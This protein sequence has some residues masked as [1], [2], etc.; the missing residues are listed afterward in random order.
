[1]SH[2]G[3]SIDRAGDDFMVSGDAMR[4]QP[5]EV[6]HTYDIQK[7]RGR[8]GTP[9]AA[10]GTMRPRIHRTNF[11][12]NR[13]DIAMNRPAIAAVAI[14]LTASLTACGNSF[15]D[16]NGIPNKDPD[17]AEMYSNVD[18]YPNVVR[19]CIDHVAFAT[20]TRDNSPAA[21]IRVPEWDASFC[22]ATPR[23]G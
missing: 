13:L 11:S 2:V 22:H 1:M 4:W 7:L 18:G 15:R 20:T 16:L 21:L 23:T 14:L 12:E 10:V 9:V 5:D 19:I 17:R 3:D 6:D 8:L